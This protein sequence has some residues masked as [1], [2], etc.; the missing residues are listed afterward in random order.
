MTHHPSFLRELIEG[1]LIRALFGVLVVIW[2]FQDVKRDYDR[3]A[4]DGEW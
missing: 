3:E 4:D 1:L 2:F